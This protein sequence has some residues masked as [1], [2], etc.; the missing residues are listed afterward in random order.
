MRT[1]TT[2]A[3]DLKPG[4]R[5]AQSFDTYDD[6]DRVTG[7]TVEISVVE[8][9]TGPNYPDTG[10]GVYARR[11]NP[12]PGISPTWTLGADYWDEFEVIVP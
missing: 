6:Q 2:A 12:A 10:V 4:D 1:R 9:I 7:T 3:E 5:I 8:K 11:E